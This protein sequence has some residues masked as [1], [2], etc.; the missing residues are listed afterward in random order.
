VI[1]SDLRTYLQ[2]KHR[3][4]LNDLVLHFHIDANALRGMM[5]KWISKGKVRL[6]PAPANCGS[7][8]CKCDPA[9]AEIYE[10]I[11]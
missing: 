11:E 9:L 4:T 3:A 7:T 6:T 10:W 8:C 2:Q 5:A 1:L